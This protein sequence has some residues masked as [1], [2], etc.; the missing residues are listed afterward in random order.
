MFFAL[1]IPSLSWK[2]F[3]S[4][5]ITVLRGALMQDHCC[6]WERRWGGHADKTRVFSPLPSC[7]FCVASFLPLPRQTAAHFPHKACVELLFRVSELF[8]DLGVSAVVVLFPGTCVFALSLFVS[9]C[10]ALSFSCSLEAPECMHSS[11]PIMGRKQT[12][13]KWMADHSFN[14]Y[15]N[16]KIAFY[17]VLCFSSLC[18]SDF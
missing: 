12:F 4:H 3:A 8:P 6:L 17:F 13:D 18:T 16:L 2:H 7:L 11:L 9:L 10:W 1:C 15:G 5:L 14:G